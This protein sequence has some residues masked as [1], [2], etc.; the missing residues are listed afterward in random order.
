VILPIRA[1]PNAK[2]SEIRGE[3]DGSLKVAVTQVAEKGKANK[4]IVTV[5]S[6]SLKLRKS[7]LELLAG[8]TS[9]KKRFLV[10]EVTV[11]E[12]RDRLSLLLRPLS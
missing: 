10:R 5:L 3:Q 4:A 11:E 8:L 12:L 1:L 9:S 2:K 7:Q 6:K